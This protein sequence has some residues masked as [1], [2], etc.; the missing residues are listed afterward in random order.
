[1]ALADAARDV[2][3][4]RPV[5]GLVCYDEAVI[6]PAAHAVAALGLHG[7]TVQASGGAATSG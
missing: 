5:A 2:A 4:S 6:V 3:A 7:P 1:M